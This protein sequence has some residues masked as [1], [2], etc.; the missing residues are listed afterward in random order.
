MQ[1]PR[2]K[3]K[4]RSNWIS[5]SSQTW[6]MTNAAIDARLRYLNAAAHLCASSAPET[7]AHLMQERFSIAQ[8]YDRTSKDLKLPNAC[9]ACGTIMIPGRSSRHTVSNILTPPNK[10][11]RQAQSTP[12]SDQKQMQIE[13]LTC[14]RIT[15]T[16]LQA[17]KL[18]PRSRTS[19]SKLDAS[20]NPKMAVSEVSDPSSPKQNLAGRPPSANLASKKRAKARKL[21]LQAVLEKSKSNEPDPGGFGFDLMDLMKEP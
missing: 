8:F 13:C 10:K 16:P 15:K 1:L 12:P 2:P 14:R 19:S 3:P 17:P 21:G 18:D 6:V 20:T 11:S 5:L 7:A 4:A 9:Q